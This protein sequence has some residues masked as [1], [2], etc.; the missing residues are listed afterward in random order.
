MISL[1]LFLIPAGF[2]LKIKDDFFN[3]DMTAK[4]YVL[5]FMKYAFIINLIMFV[6]LYLYNANK[7]F[8]LSVS[9]EN[10]GFIL[11]YMLISFVLAIIV[12]VVDTYLGRFVSFKINIRKVSDEDEKK[13]NK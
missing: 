6:V 5:T 7:E 11:K 3:E 8:I 12:P 10:I 13:N 9:L 2:A 1:L 4:D